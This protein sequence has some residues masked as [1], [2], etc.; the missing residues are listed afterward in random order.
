LN[1]KNNNNRKEKCKKNPHDNDEDEEEENSILSIHLAPFVLSMIP[2]L[3]FSY[4]YPIKKNS[5][6]LCLLK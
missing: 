1:N 4:H 6:L 2:I 5:L 3:L